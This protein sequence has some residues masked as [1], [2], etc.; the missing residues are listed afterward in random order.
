MTDRTFT[1]EHPDLDEIVQVKLADDIYSVHVQVEAR[2]FEDNADD[3]IR[4]A[5]DLGCGFEITHADGTT[6]ITY[7][8]VNRDSITECIGFVAKTFI[9]YDE[10]MQAA[11][12]D[13]ELA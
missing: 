9:T 3:T 5:F 10:S 11:L 8:S 2:T 13:L 4:I 1:S 6:D 7:R 12:L